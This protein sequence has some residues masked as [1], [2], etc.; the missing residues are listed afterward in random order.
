MGKN[1]TQDPGHRRRFRP[2]ALPPSRT[3]RRTSPTRPAHPGEGIE[4]CVK[5]FGKRPKEYKVALD[6][7]SVYVNEANEIGELSLDQLQLIFTGRVKNW[8]E[9][10]APTLRSSSTAVRQFPAPTSSSR[11]TS[12]RA[13]TSPPMPRRCR[14]RPPCSSR[15]RRRKQRH[16]LWRSRLRRRRQASQDQEN[17]H[18]RGHRAHGRECAERQV[19]PFAIPVHLREPRLWTRVRSRRT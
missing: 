7:L 18:L 1:P 9:L 4:A 17:E 6:G 12:S 14:A 15:S 8:K 19:F 10:G 16:W 13:K 11:N 3:A 5:A 2:W